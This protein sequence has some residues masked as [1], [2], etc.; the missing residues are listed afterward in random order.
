MSS[1]FSA[2]DAQLFSMISKL[3]VCPRIEFSNA[4][5]SS[6]AK[7]VTDQTTRAFIMSRRR[8]VFLIF[9]SG[10]KTV[11]TNRSAVCIPCIAFWNFFLSTSAVFSC[12][13]WALVS[14][15][16]WSPCPKR[17]PPISCSTNHTTGSPYNPNKTVD[18][19]VHTIPRAREKERQGMGYGRDKKI[20]WPQNEWMTRLKW[21]VTRNENN[22][23]LLRKYV[24]NE[25]SAFYV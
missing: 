23:V 24:V 2:T 22:N 10:V 21:F 6:A 14:P 7:A 19:S 9:Y 8:G 15:T 4:F 17:N 11:S 13:C 1:P 18:R 12:P 16:C 25:H 3:I 5:K 20:H